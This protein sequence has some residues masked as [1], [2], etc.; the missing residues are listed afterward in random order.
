M[1]PK[2]ILATEGSNFP[3]PPPMRTPEE[4]RVGN[5][6]CE[7]HR[8]KGHTTNECVQLRQLIDKLV[9]EGR[10]DHL[11]KNSKEGKINKGAEARKTHL[12]TR[13][14]PSI[15][16]S[17]GSGKLSK[18]SVKN[19]RRNHVLRKCLHLLYMDL[20]GPV[21]L[22]SINH[23]KYTLVI[24]DEYSR[25]DNGT[26]FRNHEL[27]SF[28]N[29]K[30]ISQN[31]SSPYTL[32]Q[33][34][35]AERKNKTLIEATRTMLNGSV[36]SKHFWTEVVRITCYTQNRSIIVKRH[37]KTPHEIFRERIHDISYF[38]VFGCPVFIHNHKDHLGK[39]DAKADD[40]AIRFTNT[41]EDET[42]INDSSRYPPDEFI[43][44]DDPSRQYQANS[45]ISYYVI[46]HGRSLSEL[47][48]ENHNEQIIT[49][50]IEGPSRNNTEVSVSNSMLTRSMAAKLT[51]ASASECLF[52]DFLFKI[53]PK[54]VYE[55]LKALKHP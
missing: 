6:Y 29:E 51:A 42:R 37:D 20:F 15:W 48:Q 34:S 52:A 24:V 41:S 54:K 46:P 39:F 43:H 49:Q 35:V 55:A 36:P 7:Y 4:Q 32:E 25:T 8:Q 53:E 5:G 9:K 26:E 44:E 10:L 38:H 23:E 18:K 11:V 30:E 47:T 28:C 31:S 27:E 21:S 13:L 16:C 1:T 22:M 33:N 12:E 2:E 19:F 3:K 14:T 40:E 45:D 50:P 17:H